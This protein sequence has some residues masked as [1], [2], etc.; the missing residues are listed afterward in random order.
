MAFLGKVTILGK[1]AILA[2][3]PSWQPCRHGDFAVLGKFSLSATML[4]CYSPFC[5]KVTFPDNLAS[6]D[7]GG[8]RVAFCAGVALFVA[9]TPAQSQCRL[10]CIVIH[11]VIILV[12]LLSVPLSPHQASSQL[13]HHHRHCRWL[14]WMCQPL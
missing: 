6:L 1:V 12:V 9:P 8:N 2:S 3:L 11:C 7:E 5:G 10:Q 4:S 14:A 13:W